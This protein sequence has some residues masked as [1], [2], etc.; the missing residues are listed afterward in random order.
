MITGNI[1]DRISA[2]AEARGV[3]KE[4]KRVRKCI[5]KMIA[6]PH[7]HLAIPR[8]LSAKDGLIIGLTE[9][10]KRLDSEGAP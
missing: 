10:L 2:E 7:G 4:K 1:M 9:L 6:D 5:H 3:E 8:K